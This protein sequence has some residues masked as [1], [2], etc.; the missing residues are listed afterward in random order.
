LLLAAFCLA[1]S[2]GW[3]QVLFY[4]T[5]SASSANNTVDY[6]STIGSA[7]GS[8][9]AG[10]GYAPARCTAIALD[11]SAQRVF[12]LD[13][14]DQEIWSMNLDGS[15]LALVANISTGTPTDI[16]LD[17]VHQLIYFTTCS[18]NQTGNTIQRVS[19]TG[20]GGTVLFTATG[21]ASNGVSRCTALALDL[22]HLEIMFSDAGLKALWT[23]PL[24]GGSVATSVK[25]NLLAAPLDL[26]LD[27]TNQIIY[28][29][30]G[31]T[32]QSSNTVQRINYSG[33]ANTLLYTAPGGNSVQ[34]C[35]AIEFD[36]VAAKL[37][38][39]DAGSSTLWSM[40]TNGAGLASVESDVLSTPRRLRLLTVSSNNP[41]KV[42]VGILAPG[43]S[44]EF[45]AL[46]GTVT[47][48]GFQVVVVTNAPWTGVSVVLSYPGCYTSTN[49]PSLTDISNGVGYVK[50]SDWGFDWT[51]VSYTPLTVGTPVTISLGTAHPIT[52]GLPGSW[53][54]QGFWNYGNVGHNFVAWSTDTSLPSLA[55]MTSPTNQAEVLVA[56]SIGAGRA[57]FVGWNV[58][59]SNAGPNDLTVLLNSILWA[60]GAS[61]SP[62]PK[63][64]AVAIS[65]GAISFSWSA[66]EGQ[67][68]QVEYTTNLAKSIWSNLGAVLSATN[69][70]MTATDTNISSAERFYRVVLLP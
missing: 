39:A 27:V 26:A 23:I 31:S 47:N 65:N 40:N 20:T 37:Y 42:V 34:R 58:Y 49:G 57:V 46:E 67:S 61:L 12:L 3:S 66:L 24:A 17:T 15:G 43:N 44:N 54:S 18:A 8:I 14:Q 4:A 52:T 38:L 28:Y 62:P 2:R 64:E 51:P 22:L 53:V 6:V 32:I 70:T 41:A 1:G 21:P 9:F 69:T 10:D 25:S 55:S 13:A 36:P 19:Y 7:N 16:A 56:N 33:A 68:Y 29:V 5:S 45:S 30:T 50:I 11:S 48:F 59:G 63:F 60:A 35:T